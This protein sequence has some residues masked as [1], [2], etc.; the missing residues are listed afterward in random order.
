MFVFTLFAIAFLVQADHLVMVPLSADIAKATGISLT[1]TALL[2]SVYPVAAA[3]SAFF[4][5]PFSDRFGR[6]N[7]LVFL[8]GGFCLASIGCAAA[9]SPV[10]IFLFRI[11]SGMFGGIILPNALAF[12][13][14]RFSGK[15]KIRALATLTLSFPVA[16]VLGVPLGAWL[17][18]A[19]S[20]RIPFLVIAL[21]S[22]FCGLFVL[23]LEAIEGTKIKSV[24][25]QYRELVGLW[26]NREIR[27]LFAIQFLML[28]G[29]FGFV[30]NL[31]VWLTLNF[32]MSTSE[33]GICYMQGGIGAILGN[34]AARYLLQKSSFERDQGDIRTRLISVGSL[35]M[36]FT[37]LGVTLERFGA[38]LVGFAFAVSMF[39]GS[40]RM[41]ALQVILSDLVTV[42]MRG[43]LLSMNMIVANVSMGLGGILSL[44]LLS[45]DGDRL[46]GMVQIGWIGFIT[47]CFVPILVRK[48]TFPRDDHDSRTGT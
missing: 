3:L 27:L 21:V 12:V 37:L 19:F 38:T 32:G 25:Q 41:P 40:L 17:G 15:Q 29:L 6:K 11:L 33:I 31:S 9:N 42:A 13:S 18:D 26:R 46:V 39:G 7:M 14:D 1:H 16:S 23:T 30:P 43:R 47:L 20:W 22:F 48:L 45:I 28:I 4:F 24:F 36:G 10:S 5:A 44:P 34:F 8:I 2:V 35:V